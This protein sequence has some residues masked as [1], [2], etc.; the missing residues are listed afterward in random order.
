MPHVAKRCSDGKRGV[1]AQLRQVNPHLMH[2]HCHDH[3]LA[4]ACKNSFV[5]V[6]TKI[7]QAQDALNKYYKYSTVRHANLEKVQAAFEEPLPRRN[8]TGGCLMR[9]QCLRSYRHDNV[10]LLS[11][12]PQLSYSK[13]NETK[14]IIQYDNNISRII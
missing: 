11:S 13:H 2:Y 14:I 12:Q 8:I 6:L 9:R 10:S 3:R 5:K 7:D 1:G 4:F